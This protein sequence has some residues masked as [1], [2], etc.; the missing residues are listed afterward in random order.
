M[1]KWLALFLAGATV[2]CGAGEPAATATTPDLTTTTTSVPTTTASSSTATSGTSTTTVSE[3]DVRFTGE[4][5]IGPEVFEVAIGERVD[6]W[7]LS[8]ID[9]EI[10]VHGYDLFFDLEAGVPLRLNFVADIPG[11]FEVEVH[12][13]HT[14]LFDLE[15]S[16]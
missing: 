3:I 13:G 15:V 8:D 4:D 2:A 9:D 1:L 11:I 7:V 6:V 10:H 5:V 14:K 16:G 12:T